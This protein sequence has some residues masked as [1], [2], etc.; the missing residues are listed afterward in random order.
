MAR[1]TATAAGDPIQPHE[2]KLIISPPNFGVVVFELVGTAPLVQ[3]AFSQKAA[4]A[5]AEAQR[6]GSRQMKK[7]RGDKAPKDFERAYRDAQHRMK[8]GGYGHPASAF[9][10]AL[11]SACRF[12]GI[13]M[14]IA[15]GAVFIEADGVNEAETIPLVRINGE[16]EYFEAPV[17]LR[18]AGTF[19]I[20]ARPMFRHWECDL[21]VR[22]DADMFRSDDIA[23]L[24]LR[25]GLQ[26]GIGEG[27]SDSRDSAGCGWGSFTFR[28]KDSA[29]GKEKA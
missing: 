14:T 27:R 17:R 25:A 22:F 2:K 20:R 19:D 7:K 11:K 4:E 15:K 24:V 28:N 5:M 1:K 16:P 6:E 29:P 9:R 18:K 3:C 8:G 13:A 12:S 26:V 10:E 23:N 21:T